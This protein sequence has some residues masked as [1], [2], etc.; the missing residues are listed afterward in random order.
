MSTT[1]QEPALKLRSGDA[2][3]PPTGRHR[4]TTPRT[5][6]ANDPRW[7]LAIRV[8][9]MMQGTLLPPEARRRITRLGRLLGLNT[10]ES[11]LVIAIVQDAARRGQPTTDAE[12]SLAMVPVGKQQSSAT[13]SRRRIGM[14]ALWFVVFEALV[15]YL[16]LA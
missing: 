6:A 4:A 11:N 15:L 16:F 9:E 1:T 2:D 5:L 8:R 12:A 10:F 7:V 13:S 3:A 14:I